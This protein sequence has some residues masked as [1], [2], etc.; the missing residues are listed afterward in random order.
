[1]RIQKLFAEFSVPT[2]NHFLNCGLL[3]GK[4]TGKRVERA[5]D[6]RIGVKRLN[7]IWGVGARPCG[8]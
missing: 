6:P 5:A 3:E 2:I 4:N 8:G 7:E 1:M